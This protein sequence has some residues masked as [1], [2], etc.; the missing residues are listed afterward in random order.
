[1]ACSA[2]SFLSLLAVLAAATALRTNGGLP[3][4]P[5]PQ[6]SCTPPGAYR[7]E[8]ENDDDVQ[9]YSSIGIG[10]Q[11]VKGVLDTGSF[12]LLVVSKWCSTC[13]NSAVSAY[14]YR[15]STQYRRGSET[16]SMS[17]GSGSCVTQD[18]FDRVELGCYSAGEQAIEL[19]TNCRMTVLL[20]ARFSAIIGLGPPGRAEHRARRALAEVEAAEDEF[21][22]TGKELPQR[23]K[24]ARAQAKKALEDA[25]N[26]PPALLQN[27]GISNFSVCFGRQPLSPGFMIWN[28][29]TRENVSG[30]MKVPVVSNISWGV[31][32]RDVGL[33]SAE[34][35]RMSI[36]CKEG[37]GAIIDTGTSLLGVPSAVYNSTVEA[38]QKLMGPR[39][40]CSSLEAFPDLVLQ[41]GD[42]QLRF[43]PATYVGSAYGQMNS[44]TAQFMRTETIGGTE[45]VPCQL[46][47]M[48]LGDQST[49]VGPMFILGMPFFREYYTTFSLGKGGQG[50]RAVYLSPA[51]TNCEPDLGPSVQDYARTRQEQPRRVNASKLLV[52]HWLERDAA[53]LPF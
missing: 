40:D 38:L 20:A 37:C 8:V 26:K 25:L 15:S 23:F 48:D 9:Y 42:H 27:I 21:Q 30:V 16:G 24:A 41:V 53:E 36:G 12:E 29:E 10:G 18:G 3:R 19:A 34:G 50:D 46:M 17:Y 1:M 51:G 35:E 47:L 5:E 2:L 31:Q 45:H 52:P 22:S 33:L 44:R 14:D 6:A 7:Q 49:A 28:D 43:P 39:M 11:T 4:G 13:G 32:M